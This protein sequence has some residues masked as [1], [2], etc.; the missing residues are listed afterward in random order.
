M[1]TVSSERMQCMEVWGGNQA[2]DR[3]IETPGLRIWAYSKPYPGSSSGGDVYYLSSCASGRISRILLADV[4][5]HGEAVSKIAVGLRDLMRRNINYINQS[6][7]VAGMNEQFAEVNVDGEFATALV[8]TFFAPT[9]TYSLCNA[10][11]PPPL[12]YRKASGVWSELSEKNEPAEGIADIPWGVCNEAAYFQ[13]DIQLG[14]GDMVLSYSD[15]VSESEDANG[16]QLGCEGVLRMVADLNSDQPADLISAILQRIGQIDVRSLERDDT[17]ILL[18]EA[19]GSRTPLK[20]SLL[21]PFRLLGRVSDQTE[22]GE[23][24]ELG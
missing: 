18:C 12:L 10:G 7:F 13:Q 24:N 2:V 5:G 14:P 15:A 22:L 3:N 4:S 21:A 8:S 17:T 23:V 20:N 11:H 9:R 1:S 16:Q 19:T 6:R